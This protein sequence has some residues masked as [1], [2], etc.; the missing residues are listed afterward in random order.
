MKKVLFFFVIVFI[1]GLS[2]NLEAT[3]VDNGDGTINDTNTGLMWLQ[4][5]NYYGETM[6]WYD[7]MST[8]DNFVFAGFSDWRL[9]VSDICVGKDCVDSEMSNL[10]YV[11]GVTSVSP[12]LFIDV[13]PYM[14]WSSTQ[15]D[16]E[17]SRYSFKHGTQGCSGTSSK[18]YAWAV[19]DTT[20]APEP[21]S[22]ILFIVG[23]TLMYFR[24]FKK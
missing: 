7:A 23:G 17:A 14:Y 1:L 4:D 10:F 12:G 16:D 18:R 19:R 6:N 2:V 5:A 24:R 3:L 9:P 22:S 15:C 11:E 13:R 8:I 21:I 20:V